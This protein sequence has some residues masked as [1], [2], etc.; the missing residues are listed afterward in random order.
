MGARTFLTAEA[1][2]RAGAAVKAVEARTSAEIVV[3]VRWRSAHYRG[4]C[5]LFGLLCTFAATLY[6]YL[7]PTVFH[8]SAIPLEMLLTFGVGFAVS[9]AV[10]PLR[11]LLTLPRQRAAHVAAAARAAFYDLGL[12][13]TSGRSG[14]LV[15]LS[16]F[17][18]IVEILPD[19]GVDTR[20]L[21]AGW[22]DATARMRAALRRYD[23]EA[24]FAALETLGP[25]LGEVMPR[26]SDDVNE[27]PDEPM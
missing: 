16:L 13:R 11:R 1:R 18:R 27:L 19:I 25:V 21:G 5:Y 8:V 3:A 2:Q 26:S 24:L 9:S 4:V 20:E 14:I 10:T 12:S 22:A 15:Y 17:E 6:M 23:R 7:S